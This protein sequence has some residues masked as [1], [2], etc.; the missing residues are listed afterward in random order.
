MMV[1][2]HQILVTQTLNAE[3]QGIFGALN[4]GYKNILFLRANNA[5]LLPCFHLHGPTRLR[6]HAPARDARVKGMRHSRSFVLTA[7]SP[8]DFAYSNRGS[9][10]LRAA[11]SY[12]SLS[13]AFIG[14]I[15]PHLHT[16]CGSISI[17]YLSI[18]ISADHVPDRQVMRASQP[19]GLSRNPPCLS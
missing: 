12:S 5:Y 8:V 4:V 6:S 3:N 2:F 11:A 18:S 7:S 19:C 9:S 14:R 1:D 13:F 10:I 16:I 15:L 17:W